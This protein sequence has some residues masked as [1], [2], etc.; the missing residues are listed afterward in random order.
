MVYN[1]DI[2]KTISE[3]GSSFILQKHEFIDGLECIVVAN[4]F[5]RYYL[6]MNHDYALVRYEL[7]HTEIFPDDVDKNLQDQRL[8]SRRIQYQCT[9]SDLFEVENSLWLPKTISIIKNEDN[10]NPEHTRITLDKIAINKPISDA[11][12]SDVIPDGAFVTDAIRKMVYKWGN[13]ASIGTL[14]K[15]TVQSKRQTLFR[16]IS[17]ILGLCFIVCWGI[18]EWRKRRLLKGDAE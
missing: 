6:S 12:F 9:M 8:F 4:L 16:N 13:R 14:I 15:E 1:R 11:E 17:F 3:P 7:F 2:V 18:I 10:L 5:S